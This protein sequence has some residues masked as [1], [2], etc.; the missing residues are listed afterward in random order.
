MAECPVRRGTVSL[1]TSSSPYAICWSAG[2]SAL[3]PEVV[4]RLVLPP[5]G[6]LD[7][8]T[9]REREV[10]AQMAEGRT[11]VGIAKRLHLSERTVETH[12]ANILTRSRRRRG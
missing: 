2:G 11:N 6:A 10:L 7:L 12:V 9:P 1:I 5:T 4:G 3:D 8:L